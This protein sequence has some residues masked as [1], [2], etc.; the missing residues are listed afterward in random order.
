MRREIKRYGEFIMDVLLGGGNGK[1]RD[2][3]EGSIPCVN[4]RQP[5]SQAGRR[6][7][8]RY[9]T[10]TAEVNIKYLGT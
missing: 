8:L 1:W 10:S 5:D 2:K 4:Y 7:P 9:A 3:A 6:L